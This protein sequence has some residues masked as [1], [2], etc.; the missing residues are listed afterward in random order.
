MFSHKSAKSAEGRGEELGQAGRAGQVCK[1]YA[2]V[3]M[4]HLGVGAQL[5]QQSTCL[6]C[7][8]EACMVVHPYNPSTQEMETGGP[9]I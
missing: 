7:R 3:S 2:N 1:R 9:E 5:S 4:E 8:K 6:A